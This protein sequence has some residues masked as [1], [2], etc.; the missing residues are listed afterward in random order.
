MFVNLYRVHSGNLAHVCIVYGRI[1]I[2][3]S[4]SSWGRAFYCGGTVSC[5]VWPACPQIKQSGVEHTRLFDMLFKSAMSNCHFINTFLEIPPWENVGMSEAST[6][7]YALDQKVRQ[8]ASYC[9]NSVENSAKD[10]ILKTFIALF[11]NWI[12]NALLIESLKSSKENK[13]KDF[14]KKVFWNYKTF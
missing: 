11:G 7:R 13:R 9:A 8:C 10:W 14:T 12:G 3:S 2:S 1:S 4:I 6:H 5:W